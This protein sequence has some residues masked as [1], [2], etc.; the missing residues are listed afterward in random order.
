MPVADKDLAIRCRREFIRR[1]GLDSTLIE[2]SAIQGVVTIR[3]ELRPVRGQDIDLQH[4][5]EVIMQSIRRI[6]GVRDVRSEV[7]V[8]YGAGRR[9]APQVR[10]SAIDEESIPVPEDFD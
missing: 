1:Q 7:G 3:G 9:A 6:P 5:L 2:V 4:E 8:R 10:R